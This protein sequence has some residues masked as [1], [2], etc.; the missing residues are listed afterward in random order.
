[1]W[2]IQECVSNSA[3]SFFWFKGGFYQ[4]DTNALNDLIK[5]KK[6]DFASLIFM[7]KGKAYITSNSNMHTNKCTYILCFNFS[8]QIVFSLCYLLN[9]FHKLGTSLVKPHLFILKISST[10]FHILIRQK[11]LLSLT[12]MI[13]LKFFYLFCNVVL[14][15]YSKFY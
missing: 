1:M 8:L 5:K 15:L 9:M 11:C 3:L 6:C 4:E 2:L 7:A 14:F 10:I 13:V 12:C